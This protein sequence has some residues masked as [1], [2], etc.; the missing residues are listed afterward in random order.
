[1]NKKYPMLKRMS[2]EGVFYAEQT[3]EGFEFRDMAEQTWYVTLSAE[4]VKAL[5]E[6]LIALSQQKGRIA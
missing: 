1:M 5:G 2:D 6:E 4:E 3:D